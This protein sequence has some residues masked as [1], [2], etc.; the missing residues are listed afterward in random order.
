MK[1]VL[2]VI[3]IIFLVT[4]V[5]CATADKNMVEKDSMEKKT[6]EDKSMADKESMQKEAM[7]KEGTFMAQGNILAGTKT[8]YIEYNKADYDKALA[9]DK[10]VV[11]Y[12]YANWCPICRVEQVSTF[13]AFSE[14]QL[15]NVVGFRVNYKDSDTTDD[16][17]ELAKQF[18]VTYQHTKVIIKSGEKVLKAP[19][20]WDKERY[21]SEITKYA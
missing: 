17:V 1:N 20:S 8:P 5:G 12:F 7:D 14:L 18:G 19:D 10:T 3:L 4:H 15:P 2:L 6:M 21:I 16:E 13:A 9:E 11:L